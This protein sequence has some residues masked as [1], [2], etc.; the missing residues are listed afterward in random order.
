MVGGMGVVNV[1]GNPHGVD[2]TL[3]AFSLGSGSDFG[4][5][6]RDTGSSW[7]DATRFDTGSTRGWS[8]SSDISNSTDW[9]SWFDTGSSFDSTS[10]CGSSWD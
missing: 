9:G 5:G 6:I 2:H 10:S 1:A 3:D 7:M 4:D 8:H